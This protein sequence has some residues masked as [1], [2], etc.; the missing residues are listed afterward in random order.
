MHLR[1]WIPVAILATLA[2]CGTS[3]PTPAEERSPRPVSAAQALTGFAASAMDASFTATYEWSEGGEVTV[4]RAMDRTW[5]VDVQGWAHGGEVDVT[6][7]WTAEGFFQCAQDECVRLAGITGEIPRRF[8]PLV[9]RPFTEWLPVLLDRQTPF[10]VSYTD[11]EVEAAQEAQ[12]FRLTP[13]TVV[14]EPPIPPG[15][16]CLSPSGEVAS[17]SNAQVGTLTLAEEPRAAV[18]SVRLPGEIVEGEALGRS[19]PEPEA[20]EEEEEDDESG[21]RDSSGAENE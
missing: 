17:V 15:R 19:A 4:W 14:V 20:D 2:A 18:G 10:A 1:I 3:H 16:W 9:Q 5:R 13:N 21:E 12:C 8:D 11:D 7:A 6:V